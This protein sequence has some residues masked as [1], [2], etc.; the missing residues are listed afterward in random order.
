MPRPLR[1]AEPGIIYHLT[2]RGV[3]R[4]PIFHADED[5]LDFLRLLNIT[6]ERYP[7][8]LH[9]YCLMNNHYHLLLQPLRHSLSL[10][11]QYFNS[12]YARRFNRRQGQSGHVFQARFHSLPVQT[13]AYLT[14]VSRYIHLNPY[15][16]GMVTRPQDF[17]WSNY[18]AMIGGKADR[19]ADPSFVLGYFGKDVAQ[20]RAGYQRFVEDGMTRP[21][22]IDHQVL[23]KMASWGTIRR[24]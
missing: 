2:N 9:A 19:W 15:R 8:V 14:V 22:P 7:F 23:L 4:L 18:A 3:K 20:Q 13:D 10:I 6:N 11:M 16:A 5:R 17:V 1:I 21:E 12:R 24:E